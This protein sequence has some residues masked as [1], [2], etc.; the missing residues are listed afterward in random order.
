MLKSLIIFL[1]ILF[2]QY[3]AT[4][5]IV[6]NTTE[7]QTRIRIISDTS[8]YTVGFLICKGSRR[9]NIENDVKYREE[10]SISSLDEYYSCSIEKNLCVPMSIDDICLDLCYNNGNL[11]LCI[12]SGELITCYS[13]VDV[14]SKKINNY[15]NIVRS[16]TNSH[17]HASSRINMQLDNIKFDLY[18]S[19]QSSVHSGITEFIELFRSIMHMRSS[20]GIYI[21]LTT[22]VYRSY[23]NVLMSVGK[24]I[25]AHVIYPFN[26]TYPIK[27]YVEQAFEIYHSCD[28][29]NK[30]KTMLA[31]K[32]FILKL[33]HFYNTNGD[34]TNLKN[35]YG[36]NYSLSSSCPV[37]KNKDDT[38][39]DSV[40]CAYLND[41]LIFNSSRKC[42]REFIKNT[43]DYCSFKNTLKINVISVYGDDVVCNR[44]PDMLNRFPCSLPVNEESIRQWIV[45]AR[46]LFLRIDIQYVNTSFAFLQMRNLFASTNFN[47]YVKCESVNMYHIIMDLFAIIVRGPILSVIHNSNYF[48]F[49]IV[50]EIMNTFG[51]NHPSQ[52]STI[53]YYQFESLVHIIKIYRKHIS[54][55]MIDTFKTQ[56]ISIVTNND[57]SIIA[58]CKMTNTIRVLQS[59]DFKC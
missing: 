9:F 4:A 39:I 18:T 59:I 56:L 16:N 21:E 33:A 35:V 22:T 41:M 30:E 46:S 23:T 36:T 52:M 17:E 5:A 13:L 29:M 32:I 11:Q 3:T 55:K 27:R 19:E 31:Y 6:D 50:N 40:Y 44:H 47:T 58:L 25:I 1:C 26:S 15:I 34:S 43:F 54:P 28:K 38:N 10:R 7:S 42:I 8:D 53:R 2:V 14:D 51:K 49:N 48:T 45:N 24:N 57:N 37:T 20:I 12:G